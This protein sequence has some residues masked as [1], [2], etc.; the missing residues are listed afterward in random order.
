[1]ALVISLAQDR[2]LKQRLFRLGIVTPRLNRVD[3]QIVRSIKDPIKLIFALAQ[4]L[5]QSHSEL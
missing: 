2:N 5:H 4:S 1:M 3:L